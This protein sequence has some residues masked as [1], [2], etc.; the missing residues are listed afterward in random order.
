MG[1]LHTCYS[2]VR[3]SPARKASFPPDAPRLACVKPVASVHPEPGSNS[4]LL[5]IFVLFFFKLKKQ[6][7][8]WFFVSVLSAC[9]PPV[10]SRIIRLLGSDSDLLTVYRFI[11]RNWLEHSFQN[12]SCTVSCLLQIFQC[13]LFRSPLFSARRKIF[14]KLQLL[15]LSAKLFKI[16]FRFS[17]RETL[18][19]DFRLRRFSQHLPE[20]ECK[21]TAFFFIHQIFSDVFSLQLC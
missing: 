13:S 5:F 6:D 12:D 19:P 1:R 4:S 18:S 20:S 21:I 11:C 8:S 17:L 16:Y 3:R 10:Q 15:F 14:A 2:P 7:K 9:A